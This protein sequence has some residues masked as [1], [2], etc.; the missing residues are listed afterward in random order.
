MLSLCIKVYETYLGQS[1]ASIKY[2]TSMRV[3]TIPASKTTST[4]VIVKCVTFDTCIYVLVT[5]KHDCLNPQGYFITSLVEN[6]S[7][8]IHMLCTEPV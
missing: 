5:V 2:K 3:V 8:Q 1:Y 7:R 4:T 6:K